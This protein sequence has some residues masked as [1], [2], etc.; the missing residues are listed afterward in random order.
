MSAAKLRRFLPSMA[1]IAEE[2]DALGWPYQSEI[3][4]SGTSLRGVRLFS[5]RSVPEED[6]VYI[7]REE[8]A[9]VFP[10]DRYAYLC[11]VP[12]SG[13]AD[14]ICCPRRS[15]EEVLERL[16]ELFQRYQ[17]W[18]RQL[19]GLVLSNGS[20]D[21]LC[22]FGRMLLC[23]PVII[24]DSW[25]IILAASD[26]LPQ[27]VQLENV[28]H[29]NKNYIPRRFID[30][31][32]N[33]PDYLRTRTEKRAQLW[34]SVDKG[35]T[36]RC[37]YAN[38]WDGGE[39][40]GR[41]LILEESRSFRPSHFLAAECLAQRAALILNKSRASGRWG[42]HSLDNIVYALLTAQA[43]DAADTAILLNALQWH[44]SDLYQC[45]RLQNQQPDAAAVFGQM[46]HSDLFQLFPDGYIMFIQQQ[47]CV[48]LNLSQ[49]TLPLP[50]LR[51]CLDSLCQN[52]RLYAGISS[53]VWGVGELCHAFRQ[54]DIALEAAFQLPD[55]QWVLPFSSCALDYMLRNIQT[56]LQ[57]EHL[58]APELLALLDYDRRKGTAYFSTLRTFLTHERNIPSASQTMIIHRTTLL[59][60]LKKI[61]AI[62]GIDLE[63]PDQ[64]LYL[65]L[66]FRLLEHE[67]SADSI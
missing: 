32:R 43:A 59:Y 37:I 66:S 44:K 35:E 28:A 25:F 38:L 36:R 67:K 11:M 62:T 24:H 26:G 3:N 65:L 50:Q 27:T 13:G 61:Q 45:I 52:Y 51:Q 54:A 29:S 10:V 23:N 15:P 18:E 4:G 56:D 2:L 64:R 17:E 20:L 31:F 14:H 8:D 41:L 30:S 49:T 48:V 58:A 16:L 1:M 47:Q 5:R 42:Y 57:P 34:V 7:V 60:R 33:N 12:L 39:Y 21:Q 19:D 46:I 9:G 55:Q 53:P 6:L 22:S 63:N 40:Q